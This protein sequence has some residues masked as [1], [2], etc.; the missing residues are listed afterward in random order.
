MRGTASR[1]D[2]KGEVYQSIIIDI[3][4]FLH[5]H[6]PTIRKLKKYKQNRIYTDILGNLNAYVHIFIYGLCTHFP[7]IQT[8]TR[9]FRF[10]PYSF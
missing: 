8:G 1:K 7:S 5:L 2:E 6:I 9:L 4:I 3:Q 10:G